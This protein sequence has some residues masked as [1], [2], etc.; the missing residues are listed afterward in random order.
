MDTKRHNWVLPIEA[1]CVQ[2]VSPQPYLVYVVRPRQVTG[3]AHSHNT[4]CT[5]E[6]STI[7]AQF[8]IL[9][10]PRAPIFQTY[11]VN[12]AMLSLSSKYIQNPNVLSDPI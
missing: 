5:P 9:E 12:L 11:H 6:R 1:V 10:K 7:A 4:H 3:H 8:H 2:V